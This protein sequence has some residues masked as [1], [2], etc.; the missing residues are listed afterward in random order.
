MGLSINQ[1]TRDVLVSFGP[2]PAARKMGRLGNLSNFYCQ[3]QD[4]PGQFRI[5]RHLFPL[6]SLER[7]GKSSTFMV[8]IGKAAN[9]GI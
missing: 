8:L 3:L 2:D 1:K 6:G 5:L 7:I 4:F 9:L